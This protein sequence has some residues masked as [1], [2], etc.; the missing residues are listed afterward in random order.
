[1]GITHYSIINSHPDVE[2]K[3]IVDTSGLILSL[4]EKYLKGVNTY[5]DYVDLFRYENLDAIIIC[6]PPTLHYPIAI[7]AANKNIHVFSEKPFTTQ[8]ALGQA[9]AELFEQKG[10][11]NQVGYVNRFNDVFAKVKEYLDFGV[12]GKVL[13]FKSE[14]YSC[15]IT[16]S[17]E[18]NTWRDSHENGG[19][20]LFE[21]ASH[22]IDLIIFLIGKPDKITG[23]SLTKVFSKNVEDT[24]IS[25]LLYRNGISGTLNVNWSDESY[26]KPTNKIEIFGTEGKILADQHGIKIFRKTPL[27]GHNLREGWNSLYITDVFK[28]VP[29]YVRGNE[30]T[31]EL[32]HFI[33]CIKDKEIKNRC[34]FRDA[35]GTLEEIEAIIKDYELNGKF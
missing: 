29:F 2:I 11:V 26:R 33:D 15:T 27:P 23:S 3:A 8:K 25:T 1:M 28:P 21:V 35:T 22:A 20:A 10:L 18:G 31:N 13:R 30:F 16:K 19:G 14:M 24:V 9:L 5:K 4:V 34:T 12:I 7:E 17:E 32:Y 6:T